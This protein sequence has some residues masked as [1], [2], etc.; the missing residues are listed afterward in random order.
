MLFDASLP[1]IVH[2]ADLSQSSFCSRAVAAWMITTKIEGAFDPF[3]NLEL[4][5]IRNH[6]R[7]A[8]EVSLS[9]GGTAVQPEDVFKEETEV[10]ELFSFNVC[11]TSVSTW[12][13][14]FVSRFNVATGGKVLGIQNEAT[15]EQLCKFWVS[16][17][18]W[19]VPASAAQTPKSMAIGIFA[20]AL[21]TLKIMP[22]EAL[23]VDIRVSDLWKGHAD[24][25]LAETQARGGTSDFYMSMEMPPKAVGCAVMLAAMADKAE[26]WRSTVV[27]ISILYGTLCQSRPSTPCANTSPGTPGWQS[28]PVITHT[29]IATC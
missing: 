1:D 26:I 18:T 25:I 29:Q 16:L 8:S 19:Q 5:D 23:D 9:L 28:H 24:A 2:K 22:L 12:T 10:L 13:G 14:T 21:I 27:V 4:A 7:H 20:L 6:A 11:V 15:I 3:A 17:A